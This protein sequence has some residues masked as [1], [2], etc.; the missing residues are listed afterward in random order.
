MLVLQPEASSYRL[1]TRFTLVNSPVLVPGG[2]SHGW[3][4]LVWL[5]RGG[6]VRSH[7][8]TL[9]FNGKSYPENPSSVKATPP[10]RLQGTAYL[11]DPL[12]PEA[13]LRFVVGGPDQP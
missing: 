8:A 10:G 2:S 9:H 7:Y 3:K 12:H 1:N 13:G 4:D 6:G 11:A 5:V